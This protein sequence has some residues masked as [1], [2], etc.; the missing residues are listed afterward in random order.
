MHKSEKTD[1][2]DVYNDETAEI[3]VD[4]ENVLTQHEKG[5]VEEEPDGNER[6]EEPPDALGD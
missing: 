2:V 4:R 1:E 5:E 3:V 6:R